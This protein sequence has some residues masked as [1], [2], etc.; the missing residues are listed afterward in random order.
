M[1]IRLFSQAIIKFAK[2]R[3][4]RELTERRQSIIDQMNELSSSDTEN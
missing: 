1:N 4:Y 2:E 3:M